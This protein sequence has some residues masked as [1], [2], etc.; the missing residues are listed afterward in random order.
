[1]GEFQEHCDNGDDADKCGC[2]KRIVPHGEGE[3]RQVDEERR[4]RR[5][6]ARGEPDRAGVAMKDVSSDAHRE[7][8]VGLEL[9]E[10]EIT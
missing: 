8:L 4:V 7:R 10:L 5:T 6:R 1:V 9:G 2:R 3:S